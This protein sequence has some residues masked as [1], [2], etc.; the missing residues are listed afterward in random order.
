MF[1][2][3]GWVSSSIRGAHRHVRAH[4]DMRMSRERPM[5][6]PP[7]PR[8]TFACSTRPHPDPSL[9]SL[10]PMP[11][12]GEIT[13]LLDEWYPPQHADEWDAV[14]LVCGDPAADVRRI[15][16]AVDPVGAVV[17]EA[18]LGDADLLV[19]HHP[20]FLKGVHGFAATTPKGR[21]VHRLMGNGCALFTAHTNADSPAGGVSESLALALGL[22]GRPPARARPDGRAR[23]ARRV[24]AGGRR[25]RRSGRRSP[26]PGPAGSATTT[27]P[28]SASPGEGRFRPL[29]GREPDDRR[30]RVALET[31]D[32]VRI[33][34][35]LPRGRRDEVVAA[36]LAV[37]PLRGAGV[38]RRRAR[39][40]RRG[41]DRGLRQGRHGC[42]SR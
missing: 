29:D 34:S 16:L 10:T 28:P 26:T 14:G 40:A 42:P 4:T 6:L 36:M 9:G 24:H 21:V 22:R 13:S 31:V 39:A 25:R 17:D 5:S 37:A 35:V 20:L 7:A 8:T 12:L 19:T 1:G 15:L 32:E 23:Q 3:P 38:R 27:R 41:P 2:W 18:I 30:G 11:T 33:E